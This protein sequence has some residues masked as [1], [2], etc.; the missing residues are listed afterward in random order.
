MPFRSE[1]QRKYLW[2]F[3]PDVAKKWSHKYGSKPKKKARYKG[4]QR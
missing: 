1:K 2:K 4:K 3:H